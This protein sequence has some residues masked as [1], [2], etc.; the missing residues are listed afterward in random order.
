MRTPNVYATE[1]EWL[2]RR[3]VYA[4]E[5]VFIAKLQGR[6]VPGPCEIGVDCRGVIH[7]HHRNGYSDV[8]DV[9][10]LCARHHSKEH[11]RK[12]AEAVAQVAALLGENAA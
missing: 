8:F 9:V 5:Q 12:R 4:T 1:A 2:R 7:A 11:A 6:L 10:W 3:K